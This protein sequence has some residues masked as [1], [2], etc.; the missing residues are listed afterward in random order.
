MAE[1][2][3]DFMNRMD[4][5]RRGVQSGTG[6]RDES[7]N[8]VTAPPSGIE[9]LITGKGAIRPGDQNVPELPH[10]T[11]PMDTQTILSNDPSAVLG[12][13]QFMDA[14][15]DSELGSNDPMTGQPPGAELN[16]TMSQVMAFG[17]S[18]AAKLGILKRIIGAVESESDD[19]GNIIV[20]INQDQGLL[21]KMP[22]GRYFLNRP[23][24]SGQDVQDIATTGTIEM[25]AMSPASGLGKMV[26]GKIAGGI[27]G[28][29]TGLGAGSI[30]QDLIAGGAGSEEGVD[31][32]SAAVASLFGVAAPALGWLG[33]KIVPGISA[34]ISSARNF[35]PGATTHLS[36][37]GRDAFKN[38]GIDPDRAS[39]EVIAE[40]KHITGGRVNPR[41]P[42]EAVAI[43]EAQSLPGGPV[44]LRTSDVTRGTHEQ[45]LVNQ[46]GKGA[47]GPELEVEAQIIREAQ[48][49]A[50]EAQRGGIQRKIT[51]GEI[52]TP[53]EGIDALRGS[54]TTPRRTFATRNAPAEVSG[55]RPKFDQ[56]LDKV[57]RAFSVV[58]R[59]RSLRFDKEPLEHWAAN[60]RNKLRN[61]LYDEDGAAIKALDTFTQRTLGRTTVTGA[62]IPSVGIMEIETFRRRL[63]AKIRKTTDAEQRAGMGEIVGAIDTAFEK[64]VETP[65][66]T[67]DVGTL[68]KL[69]KARFTRKMVAKKFEANKMV[70]AIME[71]G[72]ESGEM[73]FRMSATEA[74]EYLF[75]ASAVG[76]KKGAAQAARYIKRM[77]GADSPEWRG[78]QQEAIVR[79]FDKGMNQGDTFVQN[80]DR[81]HFSGN[82]FETALKTALK[83]APELMD[84]LFNP[85]DIALLEQFKRVALRIT[86][87]RPGSVSFSDTPI[88]AQFLERLANRPGITAGTLK[89][90]VGPMIQNAREQAAR[91]AMDTTRKALPAGR[92]GRQVSG[93][94]LAAGGATGGGVRRRRRR[95]PQLITK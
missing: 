35:R 74:T 69:L 47:L 46:A 91:E 26:F 71:V 30:A 60:L 25:F 4:Q 6:L 13:D 61:N 72:E 20:D 55:I 58:R 63:L 48:T 88:V 87:P 92:F 21:L 50:L 28:T 1:S 80:L 52:E 75:T 18:D 67:G 64:M 76:G 22:P 32:V 56:G 37:R 42:G 7:G 51:G 16:P 12:G 84:E 3:L 45:S 8:P 5:K 79:L 81:R 68:K 11:A 34:I 73:N 49:G 93:G 78:L 85:A 77:V 36:E 70:S 44:P 9:S 27:L 39:P 59:A 53:G 41:N 19:S 40:F 31:P 17:R 82:K 66:V 89:K 95:G 57:K 2:G 23:G 62:R 15:P 29:S 54:P 90:F 14:V 65:L 83:R 94:A 10:A 24:I 33:N 38:L 86:D 43:A